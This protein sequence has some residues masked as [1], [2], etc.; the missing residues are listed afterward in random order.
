[1][2]HCHAST[3]N[4]L[5]CCPI[6]ISCIS[7][8]SSSVGHKA[9]TKL[10]T[11]T[12]QMVAIALG[13]SKG[14]VNTGLQLGGETADSHRSDFCCWNSYIPTNPHHLCYP[15]KDQ[16]VP[17]TGWTHPLYAVYPSED[18]LLKSRLA[19]GDTFPPWDGL[20]QGHLTLVQACGDT[21]DNISCAEIC[22]QVSL[23]PAGYLEL[24][25]VRAPS[26]RLTNIV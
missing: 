1:M 20:Y 16:V 22:T 24:P 5:L 14:S 3:H 21:S 18:A 6:V 23:S 8:T 13:L 7:C 19:T 11:V 25:K 26:V 2:L 9:L 15:V 12:S 17:S 10:Y 4:K